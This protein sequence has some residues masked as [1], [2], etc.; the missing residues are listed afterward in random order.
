VVNTI[1]YLPKIEELIEKES[2]IKESALSEKDK[3][4]F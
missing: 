4:L 3:D 1:I 2:K